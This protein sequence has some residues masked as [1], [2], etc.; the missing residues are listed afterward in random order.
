MDSETLSDPITAMSLVPLV[1]LILIAIGIAI[2]NGF[3]AKRLGRNRPLWI[4]LSLIPF[5]NT[6]FY[7]YVFF[8]VVLAVLD[9]LNALTGRLNPPTT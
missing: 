9:R 2:G 7:I 5:L 4:V 6:F 8:V 3:V 1:T